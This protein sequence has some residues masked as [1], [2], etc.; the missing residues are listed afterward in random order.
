MS[1]EQKK[2]NNGPK[3]SGQ[4]E[5]FVTTAEKA[6]YE[7]FANGKLSR[8]TIGK[9]LGNDLRSIMSLVHGLLN[10]KEMF[11]ALI[12]LYYKRYNELHSKKVDDELDH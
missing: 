8:E 1:D 7:V 12:D 9:W 6:Q 11:D 10:D 4:S 2:E 5:K 3:V